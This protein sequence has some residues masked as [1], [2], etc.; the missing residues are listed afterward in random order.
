MA[1]L[2]IRSFPHFFLQALT[3]NV[4]SSRLL[5]TYLVIDVLALIVRLLVGILDPLKVTEYFFSIG[6]S[7]TTSD[8]GLSCLRSLHLLTHLTS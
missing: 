8:V 4:D 3:N 5:F 7:L 6:T 1:D 2:K